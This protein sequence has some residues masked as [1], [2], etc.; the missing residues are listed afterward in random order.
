MRRY[1]GR[2]RHGPGYTRGPRNRQLLILVVVG[3]L[4]YLL[5]NNSRGCSHAPAAPTGCSNP[6]AP[7]APPR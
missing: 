7:L 3:L 5:L 4:L 6:T 2:R 1:F